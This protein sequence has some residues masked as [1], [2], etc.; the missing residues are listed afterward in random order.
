MTDVTR[1]INHIPLHSNG[2]KPD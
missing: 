2:T 1:T